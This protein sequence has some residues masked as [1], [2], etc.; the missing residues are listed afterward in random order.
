[1]YHLLILVPWCHIHD[2]TCRWS[3]SYSSTAR[4]LSYSVSCERVSVVKVSQDGG[5]GDNKVRERQIGTQSWNCRQVEVSVN[6]SGVARRSHECSDARASRCR[7]CRSERLTHC[8]MWCLRNAYSGW[9]PYGRLIGS[10]QSVASTETSAALF[11]PSTPVH[12]ESREALQTW[13]QAALEL[14]LCISLVIATYAPFVLRPLTFRDLAAN[15]CDG[16]SRKSCCSLLSRNAGVQN[17]AS[18]HQ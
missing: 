9:P 4:S 7:L 15:L 11:A 2:V 10:G 13:V 1:M 12:L 5:P 14:R 16:Q 3:H 17:E 6:V 18:D 8:R